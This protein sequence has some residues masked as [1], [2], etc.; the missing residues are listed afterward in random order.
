[1]KKRVKFL[2][3]ALV[4]VIGFSAAVNVAAQERELFRNKPDQTDSNNTIQSLEYLQVLSVYGAGDNRIIEPKSG[5]KRA[6][7][8]EG[9]SADNIKAIETGN[10]QYVKLLSYKDVQWYS[11]S[12]SKTLIIM[13]PNTRIE[14]SKNSMDKKFYLL[15][16]KG[17][18]MEDSNFR[19][20]S[21]FEEMMTFITS[22][23]M[24]K[25]KNQ[26]NSWKS[27]RNEEQLADYIIS[28]KSD[29]AGWLG[30]LVGLG[31]TWLVTAEY[32]HVLSQYMLQAEMAYALSCVYGW[33]LSQEDLKSDLLILFDA[34]TVANLKKTINDA[35]VDKG[36]EV[37]EGTRDD[38]VQAQ[39]T[40]RI[41]NTDI[42]KS[43]ASKL[44]TK[45]NNKITSKVTGS[46]TK[47]VP[48]IA[49]IKEG[50]TNKSEAS[51]IGKTAKAYYKIVKLPYEYRVNSNSIAITRYTG[52]EKTVTV[53]KTINGKNV[54]EIA[55]GAFQNNTTIEK[56]ILPDTVTKIDVNA[57]AGCTKL[58]AFEANKL[59]E[60]N[61]AAFRGSGLKSINLKTS[62][63]LGDSAFR[64][65]KSLT[66]VTVGNGVTIDGGGSIFRDCTA[67]TTVTIPTSA[68]AKFAVNSF[69][70]AAK[71]SANSKTTLDRVGYKGP[72]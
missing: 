12:A 20:I 39:I 68:K 34:A 27:G 2:I 9:E 71:L 6:L 64:E 52:N 35:I 70:G 62:M 31:P 58:A 16:K 61:G 36:I 59:T 23:D 30:A 25:V 1:M 22:I 69:M 10:G 47:A 26:V 54:T 67:L 8:F 72:F 28:Q 38:W 56:V 60:I 43:I 17:R 5:A 21:K 13:Q 3:I 18:L 65:C 48:V 4:A 33:N 7:K 49:S 63:T 24:D 29:K 42:Y 41:S 11:P 19:A 32:A 57:F 45:L 53:P 46:V 66:S 50:V 15:V 37:A 51:N 55:Q 40:K 44:Q 14:I